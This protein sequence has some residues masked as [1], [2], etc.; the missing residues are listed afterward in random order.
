MYVVRTRVN[1]KGAARYWLKMLVVMLSL[2]C[3]LSSTITMMLFAVGVQLTTMAT[4]HTAGSVAGVTRLMKPIRSAMTSG[5]TMVFMRMMPTFVERGT[6]LKLQPLA[7]LEP[8]TSMFTGTEADPI[9]SRAL[10]AKDSA[11]ASSPP[12]TSTNSNCKGLMRATVIPNA[13][14]ITGGTRAFLM[15]FRRVPKP[16]VQQLQHTTSWLFTHRATGPTLLDPLEFPL[17]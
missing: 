1:V 13:A 10:N 12:L 17:L 15:T 5:M 2:F 4:S 9:V 7:R 6:A 16:R 14:P 8:S 11:V 3:P